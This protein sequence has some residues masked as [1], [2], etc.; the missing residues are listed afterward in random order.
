MGNKEDRV[1]YE[2]LHLINEYDLTINLLLPGGCQGETVA[3]F[4]ATV[5][6]PTVDGTLSCQQ[7]SRPENLHFT[8]VFYDSFKKWLSVSLRLHPNDIFP[9]ENVHRAAHHVPCLS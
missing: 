6:P 9:T 5:R 8:F 1:K 2:N 7:E 3:E 4:Q